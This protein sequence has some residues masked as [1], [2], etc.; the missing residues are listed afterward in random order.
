MEG[1]KHE[2]IQGELIKQFRAGMSGRRGQNIFPLGPHKV[3]HKVAIGCP[4][5]DM[6]TPLGRGV[7]HTATSWPPGVSVCPQT[8]TSTSLLSFYPSETHNS[9]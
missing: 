9:L 6:E 4:L 3:P 5:G 7:R 2:Q 1:R 8:A